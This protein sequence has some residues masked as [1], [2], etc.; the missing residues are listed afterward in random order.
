MYFFLD[1]SS[2]PRLVNSQTPL[3]SFLRFVILAIPVSWKSCSVT[4]GY[5]AVNQGRLSPWVMEAPPSPWVIEASPERSFFSKPTIRG[6]GE[7]RKLPSGVWSG[8]SAT[9]AFGTF[10]I[11]GGSRNLFWGANQGPQSKVK[12]EARIEGA[13]RPSI[14]GEARVEGAKRPRIEGEAQTEG[15][16]REKSGGR[17]LGRR[18]GEPLPRKFLKNQTWNHS[19]W[20]TFEAIIW[21]D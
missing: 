18:L 4:I 3:K 13:K 2:I 8:A 17:G 21:N 6:F 15:K 19:F 9:N 14:E 11:R 7:H 1:H 20:C 12:G 16:A 5:I 10:G